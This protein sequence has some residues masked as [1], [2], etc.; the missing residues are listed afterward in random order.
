MAVKD[1]IVD[2]VAIGSLELSKSLAYFCVAKELESKNQ[3]LTAYSLYYSIFHAAQFRLL[4]E[5]KFAFETDKW[6]ASSPEPST[7]MKWATPWKHNQV[8]NKLKTSKIESDF[9]DLMENAKNLREFYSYGPKIIRNTKEKSS[10]FVYISE[11]KEIANVIF[12][13]NT[14]YLS[15]ETHHK[16]GESIRN[17]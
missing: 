10:F 16:G 8:L 9:I 4:I 2:R 15:F 5:K 12:Q 3:P 7:L 6:I 14:I 13:D 11:Y 17:Q 1:E